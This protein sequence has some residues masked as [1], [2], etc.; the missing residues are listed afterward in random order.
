MIRGRTITNGN[1]TQDRGGTRTVLVSGIKA[2]ATLDVLLI[3]F[4]NLRRGGGVVEEVC[5][6]SITTA[7]IRFKDPEVAAR[8]AARRDHKIAGKDVSVLLFYPQDLMFATDTLSADCNREETSKTVIVTDLPHSWIRDGLQRYFQCCLLSGGETVEG[9]EKLNDTTAL[10]RFD[11]HKGIAP[12]GPDDPHQENEIL[13]PASRPAQNQATEHQLEARVQVMLDAQAARYEA[14]LNSQAEIFQEKLSV[15]NGKFQTLQSAMSQFTQQA[16]SEINEHQRRLCYEVDQLRNEVR[17]QMRDELGQVQ[18][19]LDVQQSEAQLRSEINQMRSEM[20]RITSEINQLKTDVQIQLQN[21][22]ESLEM[23]ER[24]QT[25]MIADA[26]TT[27]AS[28]TRSEIV[29]VKGQI[30]ALVEQIQHIL[31]TNQ[32][33]QVVSWIDFHSYSL[34]QQNPERE[35]TAAVLT[36]VNRSGSTSSGHST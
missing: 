21:C 23:Q 9:V 4:E 30:R 35:E 18:A 26:Q 24:M 12:E 17:T 1:A 15:V 31:P 28:Q 20:M 22:A 19:R 7:L 11:S 27:V 14:L 6:L 34:S 25:R 33:N 16:S 36:V 5:G 10:V 2:S 8:V 13:Q 3:Y 29:T 32:P